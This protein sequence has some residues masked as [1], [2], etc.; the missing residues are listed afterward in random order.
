[1]PGVSHTWQSVRDEV[2]RRI[3]DRIWPPGSL[4]PNEADLAAELGCARVT[5]NRALRDLAAQGVLD[6]R[7]KAGTRVAE[8]PTRKV[9]F[10]IPI[11]RKEVESAGQIHSHSLLARN[12]EVAPP[13]IAA[14]LQLSGEALHLRALH[15]ADGRPFVLED[16]W[17]N[18]TTVPSA[19]DVDFHVTNANEWLVSNA[20][21]TRGEITFGAISASDDD[22]RDLGTDIGASVLEGLRQTWDGERAVTRVRLVYAPGHLLR[23]PF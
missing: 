23:S 12:I 6:R 5:V 22:A 14:T 13:P 11:I 19:R 9:Q 15:L 3:Q 2:S 8:F 17:V 4:L 20:G 1:M 10:S 16:R 18:L 21:F 7:R